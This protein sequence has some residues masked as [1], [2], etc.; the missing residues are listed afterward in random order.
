MVQYTQINVI[1]H[2]NKRQV[3]NWI[4]I[5]I[6][7]E[8]ALDKIQHS[9]MIQSLTKQGREGAYLNIIIKVTYDKP[10][11]NIILNREKA[12]VSC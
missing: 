1:L 9:F 8:K 4:I 5:S 7:A 12:K 3:K 10:T 2:I 11:A 6:G